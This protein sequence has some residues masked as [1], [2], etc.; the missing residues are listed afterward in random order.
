MNNKV[1]ISG[2]VTGD[3]NYQQK[4]EAAAATVRSFEYFDQFGIEVAKRGGFGFRVV[5]PT[6]L[7]LFR[8]P[9]SN[10]R[11]GACMAVCLWHLTWCSY[12][13][14]LNDWQKS[15]G[16]RIEYRWAKFLGKIIIHQ[17][18]KRRA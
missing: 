8:K 10:Y 14:L 16:A 11:W 15:Q 5:N 18:G 6:T 13:Y 2:K 4:F 1:F 7:T 12:V 17:C 9:M 3:K